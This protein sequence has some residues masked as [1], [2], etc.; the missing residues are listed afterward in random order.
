MQYSNLKIQKT[1]SNANSF[2]FSLIELLV[3]V[4]VIGLLATVAVPNYQHFQGKAQQSEAKSSLASMYQIQEVFFSEW[5]TY[6]GDWTMTGYNPVGKLRYRILQ[7]RFYQSIPSGWPGGTGGVNCAS[8]EVGLCPTV[9]N[10]NTNNYVSQ[11][12]DNSNLAASGGSGTS[13]HSY[14]P[15]HYTGVAS[16]F[17]S[18]TGLYDVWQITEQNDLQNISIGIP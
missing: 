5:Y 8:T 6:R 12:T 16:T 15:V 14:S 4:A 7:A 2:G 17:V 11:F 13:V 10:P 1:N 9:A 18:S 3:V